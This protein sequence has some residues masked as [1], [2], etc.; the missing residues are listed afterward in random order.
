MKVSPK[1]IIALV[2]GA[3]SGI[4]IGDGIKGLLTKYGIETSPE[5]SLLLGI[6]VAVF[7]LIKY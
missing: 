1:V 2:G 3:V 6:G 4:F 7:I 5:F